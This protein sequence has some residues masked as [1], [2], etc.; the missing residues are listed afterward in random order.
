MIIIRISKSETKRPKPFEMLKYG[1]T[2]SKEIEDPTKIK[3]VM[4]ELQELIN[5]HIAEEK[6][7]DE[8]DKK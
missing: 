3:E 6:K 5:I 8:V 2:I 7:K 1:V 4:Q